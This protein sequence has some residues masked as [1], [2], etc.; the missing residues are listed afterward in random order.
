MKILIKPAPVSWIE[1]T[2]IT[3]SLSFDRH[4]TTNAQWGIRQL[5]PLFIN[6]NSKGFVIILIWLNKF[7]FMMI[8]RALYS[9]ILFIISK[10]LNASSL[11]SFVSI[12]RPYVLVSGFYPL[13]SLRPYSSINFR[14]SKRQILLMPSISNVGAFF[15]VYGLWSW[16][17]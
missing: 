13:S 14:G 6:N 8:S 1:K 7:H 9:T 4:S 15:K 12:S 2:L 10:N 11:P 17:W 5:T 16:I 3:L